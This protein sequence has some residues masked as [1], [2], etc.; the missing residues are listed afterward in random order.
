[1]CVSVSVCVTP[2]VFKPG[3]QVD[4]SAFSAP[5]FV[6]FSTCPNAHA[7]KVSVLFFSPYLFLSPCSRSLYRR[8]AKYGFSSDASI[9]LEPNTD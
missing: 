8:L 9:W 5:F 7:A 1:M 2:T 4:L 3:S 6:F